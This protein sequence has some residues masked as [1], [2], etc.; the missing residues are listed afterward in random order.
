M[1]EALGPWRKVSQEEKGKGVDEA[2]ET[3]EVTAARQTD[4]VGGRAL[5]SYSEPFKRTW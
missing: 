5:Y 3:N 2:W 4:L 1:K